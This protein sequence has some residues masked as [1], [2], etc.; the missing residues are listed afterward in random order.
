MADR[1]ERPG[2]GYAG[3]IDC[4]E[5]SRSRIHAQSAD[6]RKDLFEPVAAHADVEL[7]A[8]EAERAGGF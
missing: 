4:S 1:G 7:R 2:I 5:M 3:C 8:R 6:G